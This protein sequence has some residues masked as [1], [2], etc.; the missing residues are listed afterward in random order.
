[1][2]QRAQQNKLTVMEMVQNPNLYPLNQLMN[3]A[4][5][6]LSALPKNKI[7]FEELIKQS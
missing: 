6:A 4:D 3:A 2:N 5:L 7:I 1:M